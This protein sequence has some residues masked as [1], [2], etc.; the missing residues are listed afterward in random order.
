M[1]DGL[2]VDEER[3][4]GDGSTKFRPNAGEGDLVDFLN[5]EAPPLLLAPGL[6]TPYRNPP[7]PSPP[8][9]NSPSSS[10]FSPSS[11]AWDAMTCARR[12]LA[13]LAARFCV[14]RKLDAERGCAG[15][16]AGEDE[17]VLLDPPLRCREYTGLRA[18]IR[19]IGGY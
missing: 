2:P 12:T 3:I 16:I 5:K 19:S 11:A 7:R 6:G 13:A 9:P 15:D 18:L 14:R 10:S 8:P 17:P 1:R 4:V